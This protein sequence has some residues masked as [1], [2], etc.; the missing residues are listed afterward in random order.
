MII[1]DHQYPLVVQDTAALQGQLDDGND[2]RLSQC[3][4][5]S[6]GM[7][8]R[9]GNTTPTPPYY[10]P[11]ESG[12]SGGGGEKAAGDESS[13]VAETQPVEVRQ[14][15]VTTFSEP[16]LGDT[17]VGRPSSRGTHRRQYSSDSFRCAP[18]GQSA[19]WQA[20]PNRSSMNKSGKSQQRRG[21]NRNRKE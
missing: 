21:I 9:G 4:A 1:H 20:I 10:I 19:T 3:D 8:R 18:E 5:V 7:P 13:S 12:G 11:S 6:C 14:P 16:S 15:I 17:S 2:G